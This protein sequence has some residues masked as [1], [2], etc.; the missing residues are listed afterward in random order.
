MVCQAF[1]CPPDVAERQDWPTVIG[2]LEAR[3]AKE[4][5]RLFNG[6]K[7]GLA[8]LGKR[9]DLQRL[10]LA[11]VR[12]QGSP[13]ATWESVVATAPTPEADE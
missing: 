9:P 11:M 1:G 4:A 6:G 5:L 10:M 3:A 2:I 7:R 8:E 13:D 12:A